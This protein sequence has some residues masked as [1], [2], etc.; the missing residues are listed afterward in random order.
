M[1]GYSETIL[2]YASDDSRAGTL[3]QPDGIGEVGLGA[4]EVG[5]KLAV[6]FALQIEQDLIKQVRYQVFGC[7]FT[8]AACAAAAEL[9]EGEQLVKVARFDGKTLN[10][11][12]GGLPDE[13]SYC[14][15]LAI[16]ALQAAVSSIQQ[17]GARVAT[18]IDPRTTEPGALL[19]ADHPV[20]RALIDS[21]PAKAISAEDRHLFA[22]L[23]SIADLESVPLHQALNLSEVMLDTLLL[24]VFPA[25]AREQLFANPSLKT[26]TAP[27]I[28]PEVQNLLLGLVRQDRF[29]WPQFASLILARM[30]AARAAHPGHLWVAMGLFE[31]PE[32]SA[33]IGRHL[34][35]LLAAN[36]KKMRWKRYLF[37]QVCEMN[38][39][40]MCKS[41]VCGNCSDYALCF[42]PEDE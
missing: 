31:R 33:A 5:Q 12:L 41:P 18:S 40:L 25:V 1:T 34:P 29:G 16:E 26:A 8:M 21:A 4:E 9:A 10:Q 27:E 24:E 11:S 37:K 19:T 39:G 6:R 22:C 2:K 13:R 15:D 23:L 42:A 20:Y 28:N 14:A 38:G 17:K 36:N 32:L 3:L 7:G 35:S 30:I